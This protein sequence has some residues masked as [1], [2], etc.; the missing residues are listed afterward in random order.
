[1]LSPLLLAAGGAAVYFLFKGKPNTAVQPNKDGTV[2]SRIPAGGGAA[3]W[4]LTTTPEKLAAIMTM[5]Q[6]GN[7]GNLVAM[8]NQFIA[9]GDV[10]EGRACMQ[11]AA[12]IAA[13][14]AGGKKSSPK[15]SGGTVTAVMQSTEPA[16]N[17]PDWLLRSEKAA[18]ESASP[19]AMR[20]VAAQLRALGFTSAA[21]SLEAAA[22]AA[23]AAGKTAPV[24]TVSPGIAATPT[25][26]SPVTYTPIATAPAPAPAQVVY[27]VETTTGQ[28]TPVSVQSLPASLPAEP[29]TK[30]RQAADALA[31]HLL[32]EQPA[33]ARENQ[34]LVSQYQTLAGQKA[35]G[36][37]G[38]GTAMSLAEPAS[39]SHTPPAPRYWPAG[40]YAKA[41]REYESF[42]Q[43]Q[44]SD[45]QA[46]APEWQAALSHARDYY[47]S[48]KTGRVSSSPQPSAKGK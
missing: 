23:E 5:A 40:T 2:S 36:K 3:A 30:R 7:A 19:S 14:Q 44:A 39:G 48:G 27:K 6:S 31:R 32:V 41:L 24:A 42:L 25:Q 43:G 26:F 28:V 33:Y 12:T 21:V 22:A 1:M 8:G 18:C 45:D 11:L 9:G 10:N 46:R 13:A 47:P 20:A 16:A 29:P 37:Y 35:D 38:K 34:S 4:T 15:D 17:P